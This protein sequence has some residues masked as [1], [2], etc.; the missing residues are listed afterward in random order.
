LPFFTF[1]LWAS[2]WAAVRIVCINQTKILIYH[3]GV[4]AQSN[5]QLIGRLVTL[6]NGDW[7]IEGSIEREFNVRVLNFS[8][9]VKINP[10]KYV[11]Y[12]LCQ[13]WPGWTAGVVANAH[14]R[15]IRTR[16]DLQADKCARVR[17]CSDKYARVRICI[18]KYARCRGND[19]INRRVG[20]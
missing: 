4:D 16:A 8:V 18:D 15:Q 11:Q 6:V 7:S 3:S 17:I 13:L 2:L 20:K 1:F 9:T 5:Y 12:L 10:Q 19:A 14:A